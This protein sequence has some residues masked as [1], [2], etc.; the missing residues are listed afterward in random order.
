MTITPSAR[1]WFFRK[2]PYLAIVIAIL[3]FSPVIYW[4]SI[5]QWASFEFQS[6]RR[7][8][9][10]YHFYFHCFVGLLLL[11]LTHLGLWGLW[12]LIRKDIPAAKLVNENTVTFILVFT[13]LPLI[14]FGVFSLTHRIRFNW[15]GPSLLSLLPWLALLISQST[16][17][18]RLNFRNSWLIT[19]SVLLVAYGALLYGLSFGFSENLN[20]KLFRKFIAWDAMTKDINALARSIQRD[21]SNAPIIIP[22]DLYNISSELIFYQNKLLANGIIQKAYPVIGRHVFGA[23]SLMYRYWFSGK[24]PPKKTVILVSFNNDDF[25]LPTL[26]GQVIDETNLKFIW[27]RSQGKGVKIKPMYYKIVKTI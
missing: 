15:I 14:T 17:S 2:E 5:H 16:L 20:K 23:E 8:S 21:S 1:K 4:N 24:I 27:A 12:K 7:F 9:A 19:G 25:Q 6:T 22:L 3:L 18:K 13:F 10:S 26:N 11:F